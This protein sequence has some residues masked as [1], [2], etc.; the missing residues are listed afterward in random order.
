ML[1]NTEQEAL[2]DLVRAE[3]EKRLKTAE[4]LGTTTNTKFLEG[5]LEKLGGS[6]SKMGWQWGGCKRPHLE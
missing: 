6:Q 3:I 4:S 2:A 5:L 1:T